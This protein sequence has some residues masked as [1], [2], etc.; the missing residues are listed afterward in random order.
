MR[1]I[2]LSIAIKKFRTD[3]YFSQDELSEKSGL[4]LRTIQRLEKGETEP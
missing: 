1:N 3:K 4:S 2:E